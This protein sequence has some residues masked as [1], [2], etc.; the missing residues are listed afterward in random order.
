MFSPAEAVSQ[1]FIIETDDRLMQTVSDDSLFITSLEF[2]NW[3]E[4]AAF[5]VVLLWFYVHIS[6]FCF[7]P[8]QKVTI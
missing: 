3:F 5:S 1:S 2:I 6:N 4:L 7:S 8:L